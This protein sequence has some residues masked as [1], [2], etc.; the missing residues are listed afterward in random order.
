MEPVR[1]T[2]E[3]DLAIAPL[4]LHSVPPSLEV[5]GDDER[6]PKLPSFRINLYVTSHQSPVVRV[7]ANEVRGCVTAGIS[8]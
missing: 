7:F 8:G 6:L 3:A 2:L 4:L 5:L 1:A